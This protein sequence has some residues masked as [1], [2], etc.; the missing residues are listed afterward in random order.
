MP[1]GQSL[2][3]VLKELLDEKLIQLQE[4][5][6][7]DPQVKPSW[8]NDLHY[9]HYHQNKGHMTKNCWQLKHAVQDLIDQKKVFVEGHQTNK[10]HTMF[11]NPLPNYHKGESSSAKTKGKNVGYVY[12][13]IILCF[14]AAKE[15]EE[16]CNQI[17]QN[18]DIT[19]TNLVQHMEKSEN[20][21]NVIT[22]NGKQEYQPVN[23][24]TRAQSKVILKGASISSPSVDPPSNQYNLIDKLQKIPAQI[25][26]LE[27]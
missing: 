16:L 24:T 20:Q 15:D 4:A 26:I 21:I 5:R 18:N 22:L 27:L 2:E 6:N 19:S 17:D 13:T 10:Y 1:L 25:S 8:W 12:D 9:Y 7:W 3:S 14:S 23:A 11:K